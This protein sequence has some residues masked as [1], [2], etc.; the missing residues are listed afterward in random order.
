[1]PLTCVQAN[2]SE[3]KRYC[4]G[5]TSPITCCIAADR[6][7]HWY[8]VTFTDPDGHQAIGRGKHPRTAARHAIRRA[9]SLGMDRDGLALSIA[10]AYH[11]ACEA[12]T[13]GHES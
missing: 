2:A 6:R 7:P 1:M 12:G 5:D 9:V 4:P 11:R 13:N 8:S 3:H 10:I